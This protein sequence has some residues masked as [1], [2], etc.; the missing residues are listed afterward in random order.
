MTSFI[1]RAL[2][3]HSY[4]YHFIINLVISKGYNP[5]KIMQILYMGYKKNLNLLKIAQLH[6]S[7]IA[8]GYI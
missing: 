3:A 4:S 7:A 5:P 6:I 1:L 2:F 8:A